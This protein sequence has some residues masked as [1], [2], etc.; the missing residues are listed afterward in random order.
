VTIKSDHL[1]IKHITH[2]I[3]EGKGKHMKVSYQV[4]QGSI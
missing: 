4:Q 3:D 2:I 1:Q